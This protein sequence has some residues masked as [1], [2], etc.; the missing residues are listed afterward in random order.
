M[1]NRTKRS[2]QESRDGA[3]LIALPS[4]QSGLGSIPPRVSWVGY[5]CCWFS[6]LIRGFSQKPTFPNSHSTRIGDLRENQ[7]RLIETKDMQSVIPLTR[8]WCFHHW[9]FSL[10]EGLFK[11]KTQH[12]HSSTQLEGSCNQVNFLRKIFQYSLYQIYLLWTREEIVIWVRNF[13]P[14]TKLRLRKIVIYINV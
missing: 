4:H 10:L 14:L 13:N 6:S 7:L 12:E 9:Q 3:V 8:A 1:L 5:V 2:K 11:K